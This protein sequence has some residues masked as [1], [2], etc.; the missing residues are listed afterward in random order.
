MS[1]WIVLFWSFSVD[2]SKYA[3]IRN[4]ENQEIEIVRHMVTESG[5]PQSVFS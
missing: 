5:V 3:L 4:V 1:G 2:L